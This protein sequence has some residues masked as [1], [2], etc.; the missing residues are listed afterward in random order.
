MRVIQGIEKMI[1]MMVGDGHCCYK[2][3]S[4]VIQGIEKMIDM[5][6]GEGGGGEAEHEV[7]HQD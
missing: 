3:R 7:R 4:V 2:R 1:D 6:V 5:M